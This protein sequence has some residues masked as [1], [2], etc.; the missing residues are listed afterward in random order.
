M[1]RSSSVRRA[2]AEDAAGRL[3]RQ[4]DNARGLLRNLQ[5]AAHAWPHSDQ[6]KLR[7][8]SASLAENIGRCSSSP[9]AADAAARARAL[10]AIVADIGKV[11]RARDAGRR[12]PGAASVD[13]VAGFGPIC[14]RGAMLLDAMAEREGWPNEGHVHLRSLTA[15]LRSNVGQLPAQGG[16]AL[17]PVAQARFRGLLAIV[18]EIRGLA[19]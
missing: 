2:D 8:L 5:D 13:Q 16:H 9:T 15:V 1:L 6:L 4:A 18:A 14:E 17:D 3:L 10:N 19:Q 12:S 11:C 7:A